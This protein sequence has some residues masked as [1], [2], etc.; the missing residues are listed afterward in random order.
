MVCFKVVEISSSVIN[1]HSF[2]EL[3]KDFSSPIIA[4]VTIIG[5][6]LIASNQIKKQH[7]STIKAQKEGVK[8]KTRI[9]VFNDI[10]VIL[11]ESKAEISSIYKFSTSRV[12]TSNLSKQYKEFKKENYSKEVKS[13]RKK[14]QL[15]IT[16]AESH[17][18][19]NVELFQVFINALESIDYEL[20]H[21]GDKQVELNE[22]ELFTEIQHE[23]HEL[24]RVGILKKLR[25][26]SHNAMYFF[27]DFQICLQN[28]A[29]DEIFGS[30][31]PSRSQN[32]F[33]PK[34]I[35]NNVSD[36]KEFINYL[37]TETDWGKQRNKY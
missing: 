31:V 21:L 11:D 8:V 15:A 9:E 16:K 32:K 4:F 17:Q 5:S 13:L 23:K 29:Y 22:F 30:N 26:E 35:S 6:L 24:R 37:N 20:I 25:R 19:V 34:V 1:S 3:M 2:Y 10:N 7:K 18:I 12:L 27:G 33:T 14:L 28:M 36:L